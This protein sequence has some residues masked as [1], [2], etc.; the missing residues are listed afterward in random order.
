[1][2]KTIA[3]WIVG[4]ILYFIAVMFELGLA[5]GLLT[6]Q[7]TSAVIAGILVVVILL[8]TIILPIVWV[9][10]KLIGV[11]VNDEEQGN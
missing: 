2:Y 4:I 5:G 6:A 1:M 7:S 9:I 8:M 11:N 3:K 10:R